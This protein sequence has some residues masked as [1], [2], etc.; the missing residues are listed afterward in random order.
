MPTNLVRSRWTDLDSEEQLFI[1]LEMIG[2][3]GQYSDRETNP[4]SFYLPLAG[5]HCRVKLTF[6][7]TKQLIAIEPGP[8]FDPAQWERVVQEIEATG[9]IKVGRDCSFS[10]YRVPG[11]WRGERS[12]VQILPPPADAPRAPCPAAEHPVILEFPVIAGGNCEVANFRRMRAHRRFTFVLN[13]L[14]AAGT[15]IQPRRRRHLYSAGASSNGP[16]MWISSRS[17]SRN[18][19]RPMIR[20]TWKA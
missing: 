2:K 19:R 14:L 15:T 12:G 11:S 18:R 9:P 10:G 20:S 3:H 13:V 5:V 1:L 4:N 17:P 7:G 16:E 8:A 6:A